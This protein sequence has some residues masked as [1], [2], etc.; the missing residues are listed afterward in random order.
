M[1]RTLSVAS[2]L[3]ALAFVASS[4]NI[5]S[6]APAPATPPAKPPASSGTVAKAAPLIGAHGFDVTGM[7]TSVK[8]CDDF[9][10]YAVGKWR[11]THPLDPQYSRFGRFEEVAERNRLKLRE[12]LDADAANTN[13]PKGS[14]E[15]KVGDF[16]ASCMNEGAVEAQGIK[17]I[18]AELER[19]SAIKSHDEL[20]VEVTRLH[21]MGF[22][23]L[24]RVGGT[25]DFK[26]SKMIIAAVGSGAVGLPDRDYYLRDDTRFKDVRTK[27]VEHV[28]KMFALTGEDATAA[29]ADAQHILQVEKT[30]TTSP[31]SPTSARWLPGSTGPST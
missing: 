5:T 28:A 2:S 26:N 11:D 14:I 12:I 21:E 23:P 10:I 17:P 1:R 29:Q 6:A 16:Y 18:A 8:A 7:N 25:N 31:P 22:A 4:S 3:L 19:I 27:Y 9:Y 15:Q 30:P 20:M 24:F 13:A